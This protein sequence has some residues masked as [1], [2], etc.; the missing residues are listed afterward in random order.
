M[1]R[2]VLYLVVLCSLCLSACTVSAGRNG[3]AID[4]VDFSGVQTVRV[5]ETPTPA[6][7][8]APTP[9][10]TPKPEDRVYVLSFAGDCTLGAEEEKQH[11]DSGFLRVVG[12]DYDYPFINCLPYF[13]QDDFTL[14]NLEGALT[15]SHSPE[16]KLFRFKGPKEYTQILLDGSIEAVT[17][18]NN[19]SRDYGKQGYEDT[20]QA[21]DEAG[22]AY[23]GFNKPLL[24]TLDGGFTI[25]IYGG[26]SSGTHREQI[27]KGI[28]YLKENGAQYIVAVFHFGEENAYEPDSNQRTAATYAVEQGADLVIGHHPHV[29]QPVY[30][31]KGVPIVY[32]VGNF[33]FG[34]NARPDDLD[35]VVVQ[36]EVIVSPDGTARSGEIRFIPFTV[37][38]AGRHNNYQPAPYA[39]GSEEYYRVYQKLAL[40][41]LG[42]IT[43]TEKE[44]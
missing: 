26:H 30:L 31:Y 11:S 22:I 18:A 23:T 6:P 24:Y 40:D 19:H 33:C 10:P 8:P 32:S 42:R 16:D 36:Q 17:I 44:D 4:P 43:L 7:T 27:K 1:R 37:S 5:L 9:V 20:A 25:G 3:V 13:A 41:G 14:V 39:R 28:Q 35:T 15:D 38:S 21:L 29:L 2:F 12:D 34:G